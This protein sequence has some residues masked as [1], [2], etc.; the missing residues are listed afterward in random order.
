MC[1]FDIVRE[2]IR[3]LIFVYTVRRYRHKER[4]RE[5]LTLTPLHPLRYEHGSTQAGLT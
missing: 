2:V 5:Y 4:V 3:T 1:F